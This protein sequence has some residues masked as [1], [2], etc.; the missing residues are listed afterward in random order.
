MKAMIRILNKRY[1]FDVKAIPG[2]YKTRYWFLDSAGNILGWCY[3][4]EM[5]VMYNV[6]IEEQSAV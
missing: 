5:K 3:V 1:I 4:G 6:Q 2:T